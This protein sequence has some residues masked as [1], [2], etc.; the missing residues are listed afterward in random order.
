MAAFSNG[1]VGC[2]HCSLLSSDENNPKAGVAGAAVTKGE[3]ARDSLSSPSSIDA[4]RLA[5][6]LSDDGDFLRRKT[7]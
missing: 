1:V 7:N 4:F 3:L 2:G 5:S 6:T